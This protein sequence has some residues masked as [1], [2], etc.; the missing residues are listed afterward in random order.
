MLHSE[1]VFRYTAKLI[2]IDTN[3][4]QYMI[5]YWSTWSGPVFGNRQVM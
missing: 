1:D 5:N 2:F 3:Y 4:I